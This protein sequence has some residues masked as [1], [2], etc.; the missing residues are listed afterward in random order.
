MNLPMLMRSNAIL[1]DLVGRLSGGRRCGQP[2][3]RWTP[4]WGS[5]VSCRHRGPLRAHEA[6][7]RGV[8]AVE[9]HCWD[10]YRAGSRETFAGSRPPD[11]RL[12]R[13]SEFEE[14][15]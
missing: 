5:R 4:C 12:S 3:G 9:G 14:P 2:G 8:R 13:R 15:H 6:L 11:L 10:E 7:L 1:S